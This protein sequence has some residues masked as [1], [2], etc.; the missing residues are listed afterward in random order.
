MLTVEHLNRSGEPTK[1]T[2]AQSETKRG[3][4]N[5]RN[6]EDFMSFEYA[7]CGRIP[8]LGGGGESEG[9]REAA[10]GSAFLSQ[11]I[12]I[13]REAAAWRSA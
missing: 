1:G 11:N 2:T 10:G 7:N 12:D 9:L 6:E 13:I 3:T 5:A 8:G 4:P